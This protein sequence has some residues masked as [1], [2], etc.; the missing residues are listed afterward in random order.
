MKHTYCFIGDSHT[1]VNGA[2]LELAFV[3]IWLSRLMAPEKDKATRPTSRKLRSVINIQCEQILSHIEKMR[4][5]DEPRIPS[6][7]HL[8]IALCGVALAVVD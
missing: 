1:P 7:I 8:D 4:L 3:R 5:H 2:L 6:T